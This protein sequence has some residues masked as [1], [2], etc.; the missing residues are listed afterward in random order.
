MEAEI[1]CNNFILVILVSDYV[2]CMNNDG[3][4]VGTSDSRWCNQGSFPRRGVY[5][6]AYQLFK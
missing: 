3:L 4:M 1:H 5:E 6:F 2:S